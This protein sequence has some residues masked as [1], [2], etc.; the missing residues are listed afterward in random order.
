MPA[1]LPRMPV[2]PS[3]KIDL[4]KPSIE[5]CLSSAFV[6][7]NK[8]SPAKAKPTETPRPMCML[9]RQFDGRSPGSRVFADHRLPGFPVAFL[10]IGSPFTVAGTAPALNVAIRTGFPFHLL[11]ENHLRQPVSAPLVTGQLKIR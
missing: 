8:P 3:L 11:A 4:T 9:R 6:F 5:N 10:A 7:A 1:T 2:V